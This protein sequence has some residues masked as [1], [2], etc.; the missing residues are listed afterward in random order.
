[1]QDSPN[2]LLV[3]PKYS[4]TFWSFRHALKF[5][6]KKAAFPPLGLLTVASMLPANWP[7]KLID[8]NV[9]DFRQKDL[10]W[11]DMVFI[12]AMEIQEDSTRQVLGMAK[13]LNKTTVAGGPLFSS[14]P[15]DF[16]EVDHILINEAELTLPQFLSDLRDG[17]ARHIYKTEGFWATLDETPVPRWDLIDQRNYSTLN[18]QYS[19]G[20]PY[21]CEFCDITHLNGRKVR[22]KPVGRFLQE[23][24]KVYEIGWKERLF[25]VDDNFIGN[26]VTLKKQLLPELI[27]WQKKKGNPFTFITQVSVELA[28]DDQLINLMTQAGFVKLFIGIETPEEN[29]LIECGKNH[30]VKRDLLASVKKLQ[31]SG[32]QVEGGFIVGFD[33]DPLSIFESQIRFIQ[34]SGIVTAMVGLLHVLPGTR[35]HHRLR[36]ENRMRSNASGDNMDFSLNFN[37]KMDAEV[38]IKGYH[39]ILDTIYAPR[40]YYKRIRSFLKNYR[41]R[42]NTNNRPTFESFLA[43]IRSFYYIGLL[44]HSRFRFWTLLLWTLFRKPASLPIAVTLS[45]YGYHFRRIIAEK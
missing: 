33:N 11:C 4:D 20:C 32:F 17:T 35:L 25:I 40:H 42:K 15:E 7:V 34:E 45:I 29:S 36:K 26:K 23:L 28:D 3:Y 10:E 9:K 21:D 43:L 38:L 14:R 2:I 30:N 18:I 16:D 37:P 31:R 1:M 39:K 8:L 19:R 5:V 6:G 27:E 12:S 24:E 22:A 13:N 44:S 41:P